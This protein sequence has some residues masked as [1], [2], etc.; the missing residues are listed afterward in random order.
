MGGFGS[1]GSDR[2][3]REEEGKRSRSA[4][5]EI[6]EQ[7][8]ILKDNY[9]R[10]GRTSDS[11]CDREW[12]DKEGDMGKCHKRIEKGSINRNEGDERR[13]HEEGSD[14]DLDA[15]PGYRIK[16]HSREGRNLR[17]RNGDND[18]AGPRN[19]S[20]KGKDS[21]RRLKRKSSRHSRRDYESVTSD[22]EPDSL[23]DRD[24]DKET[25]HDC[26]RKSSKN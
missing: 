6:Y 14:V 19:W 13:S 25:Q 17:Q 20:D 22:T 11:V 12:L 7:N 10:K 5:K 4:D 18:E 15:V 2:R 9:K 3:K 23:F 21:K 1:S 8:I 26:S 24:G 16:Q